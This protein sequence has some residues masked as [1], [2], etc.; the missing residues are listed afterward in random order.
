M[1]ILRIPIG[2]EAEVYE[3][4]AEEAESL[5]MNLTAYIR[6]VLTLHAKELK[7]K[8]GHDSPVS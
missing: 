2:V 8:D 7:K 1:A 5:E 4:I 3:R 6:M